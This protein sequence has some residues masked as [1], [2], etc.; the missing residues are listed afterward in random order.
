MNDLVPVTKREIA[1][2]L[3]ETVCA[4]HIWEFVGAKKKFPDW[5][6]IRIQQ[7]GFEKSNDFII[8][9]QK[10]KNAG[11]PLTEYFVTMDMGKHLAM[12]ERNEK[13]KII[14]QWF[15]DRV[16]EYERMLTESPTQLIIRAVEIFENR[17]VTEEKSRKDLELKYENLKQDFELKY[18]EVQNVPKLDIPAR[19]KGPDNYLAIR[20]YAR[21]HGKSKLSR[22]KSQSLGKA[23]SE[24]CRLNNYKIQKHESWT[25]G[26]FQV[27][28]YPEKVLDVVFGKDENKS[29]SLNNYFTESENYVREDVLFS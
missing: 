12:M 22:A 14:R 2:L 13:G 23:A 1:G 24:L 25:Y 20:E 5:I 11:R 7:G 10:G 16:N 29:I 6:R 26:D 17:L 4:R 18:N 3:I 15:I 28:I 8:L 9:P 27:N 21:M 19:L